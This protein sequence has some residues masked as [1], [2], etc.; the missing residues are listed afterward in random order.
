MVTYCL[1]IVLKLSKSSFKTVPKF[2]ER[3][4][5]LAGFNVVIEDRCELKKAEGGGGGSV[6][7]R[8][9]AIRAPNGKHDFNRYR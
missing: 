4:F 3:L 2:S 1:K 5:T 9:M 7:G 8:Y 6:V